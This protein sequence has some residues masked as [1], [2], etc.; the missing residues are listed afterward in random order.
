MHIDLFKYT[1]VY[2]TGTPTP[3]TLEKKLSFEVK[4][5]Y[6]AIKNLTFKHAHRPIQIHRCLWHRNLPPTSHPLGPQPMSKQKANYSQS[7]L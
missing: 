3:I 7:A 2:G 5:E 6:N 4:S 1:Y